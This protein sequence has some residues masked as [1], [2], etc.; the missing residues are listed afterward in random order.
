MSAFSRKITYKMATILIICALLIV[1]SLIT[2]L[3]Q[4]PALSQSRITYDDKYVAAL[5]HIGAVIPQ[6]ETLATSQIY[7]QVTYFTDHKAKVPWVKTERALV[8]FMW[9]NNCTYLLVPEYTTEAEPDS[10]P[11]LIQFAEKPFEKIFNFYAEYIALPKS[12][13]TPSLNTSMPKPDNTV[14]NIGK[15]INGKIF[16]QLFEK[17]SDYNTEG[18]VLHLYHLRSNITRDNLIKATDNT[19]PMLSVSFP[20]NGTIITSAFGVLRVNVT[21]LAEDAGSNIKQVEISFGGSPFKLA[22]PQAPND[23]ST[24]SAS[25][26]VTAGTKKII[27]RAT[28]KADNR[29]WAPIFITIK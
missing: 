8:Q 13:N 23:W 22:N 15:S 29:V 7:P 4:I 16:E 9:K 24:W 10:T 27:V 21:G 6:N 20:A 14:L 25:D 2:S 28:D 26:I 17:I 3:Q 5:R 11:A 18:S 1:I 19:K 12:D